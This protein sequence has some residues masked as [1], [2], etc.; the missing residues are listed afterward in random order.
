MKKLI[1]FTIFISLELTSSIFSLAFSLARLVGC[2]CA[3][4]SSVVAIFS[5]VVVSVSMFSSSVFSTVSTS[6]IFGS[7]KSILPK[8][9]DYLIEAKDEFA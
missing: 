4:G 2:K 8:N 3:K 1:A 7:G 5:S 9:T 6:V